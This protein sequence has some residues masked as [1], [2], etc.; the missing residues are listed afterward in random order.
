[1]QLCVEHYNLVPPTCVL[2]SW[3]QFYVSYYNPSQPQV[4]CSTFLLDIKF[5]AFHMGENVAV[6][7]LAYFT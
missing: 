4:I 1:M 2:E 3:S 7:F 5:L 6:I